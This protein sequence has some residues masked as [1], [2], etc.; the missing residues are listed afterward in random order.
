MHET[1]HWPPVTH[2][3]GTAAVTHPAGTAGTYASS[4]ISLPALI[5]RL[6]YV[7]SS[8]NTHMSNIFGKYIIMCRWHMCRWLHNYVQVVYVQMIT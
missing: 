8:W 2:P 6:K 1:M 5:S 3:A 4:V 7:G